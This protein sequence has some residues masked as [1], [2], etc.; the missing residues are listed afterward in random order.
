MMAIS[1]LGSL[2]LCY[3]EA[4]L[5]ITWFLQLKL[6][7]EHARIPMVYLWPSIFFSHATEHV[8]PHNWIKSAQ[9][10]LQRINPYI[11]NLDCLW[12]A[13]DGDTELALH[14]DL[15]HRNISNRKTS[16]N[17]LHFTVIIPLFKPHPNVCQPLQ[18]FT[19]KGYREARAVS[20]VLIREITG[21]FG[22]ITC[23]AG[24]RV[25]WKTFCAIDSEHDCSKAKT[26]NC[27][28]KF[29]TSR[30]TVLLYEN[31]FPCE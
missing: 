18:T 3:Q 7:G 22:R 1:T 26:T 21:L 17:T 12:M 10:G 5:I 30:M 28:A 20:L 27:N 6:E 19:S 11:K 16:I 24:D 14:L 8:I 15:P 25:Y 31:Y 23:I 4:V 2:L 29:P 13:S 9:Q